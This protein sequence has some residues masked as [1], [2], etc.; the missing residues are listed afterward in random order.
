M[1][2]NKY[3]TFLIIPFLGNT[4]SAQIF[5]KVTTGDVVTT[6]SNSRS[7]NWVDFNNDGY[8][9][10]M[11]TN[12]KPPGENN[13]LYLNNGDGTFTTISGQAIVNDSQPSY[14]A[15]W[16]D[17]DNDGDIDAFVVNES[18]IN[19]MLY[20]NN[21]DNTFE[22][23]VDLIPANDFG[24]S[25]TAAW[26][27]YDNDGFVDLYVTNFDSTKM[28][29][30]YKNNAGLS[31]TKILIGDQVTDAYISRCVNW[32]D[33]DLD[34]DADLF[35]A[36]DGDQHENCYANN[37]D[38]SFTKLTDQPLLMSDGKT[39]SSSWGDVDNDG[40]FDVFLTNEYGNN[41]LFL[42]DGTGYF[43]FA[44]TDIVSEGYGNS[45]GS[46][47]ADIDNDGDLDL[48]VTNAFYGIVS[49]NYLYLNNGDGTF[50][51][52]TTDVTAND[53]G[54]SYG[55]AFG[56]YDRDGDMDLLV[57]TC[58]GLTQDNFLYRNNGNDN[59]W[60]ELTLTGVQTNAS[61]IGTIVKVKAKINGIDVWQMREV[62]SQTGNC[63][64]NMLTVHF[65][66]GNATVID[67]IVINWP[68]NTV[69]ILTATGVN[70][71][72]TIYE[73]QFENSIDDRSNLDFTISPNPTSGVF[74]LV[75]IATGLLEVFD[76]L[77]ALVYATT[78]NMGRN[79]IDLSKFANGPYI[80][81]LTNDNGSS[82][83]TIVKQ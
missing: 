43:V 20:R 50:T 42:N 51:Q 16:A 83:K 27:D 60:L 47:F 34:G 48:F 10:I 72:A 56:D 33:Y 76:S 38:K 71:I 73:G 12:A 31:F 59:A 13:F 37:G 2:M 41:A 21:G 7:C 68:S 58:Y 52:N 40:D 70:Q 22:Q 54:W 35:V 45:F 8:Q 78:I 14:G 15:T 3:F 63:G 1:R 39:K 55:N 79:T 67:S 65:G 82:G 75:G 77:G 28:N 74:Q 66:L 23:I 19:N 11:I 26:G 62:S 18:G 53:F 6:H 5:T 46:N 69:D 4:L 32:I 57:A 64:Q 17:I 49:Y 36:N 80:L 9:D 24:Y 61:A 30:L 25:E 44:S 29:Y 81:V